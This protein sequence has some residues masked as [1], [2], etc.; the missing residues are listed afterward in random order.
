MKHHTINL[1]AVG[2]AVVASMIIP[3][4][5]Y[6]LFGPQW[7]DGNELTEQMIRNNA[8]PLPYIIAL[9]ASIVTVFTMAWLFVRLSVESVLNGVLT[10]LLLGLAFYVVS[11][12]TQNVFSLRPQSLTLIDG[13]AILV[14]MVVS[15]AILGGWRKYT[16]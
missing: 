14:S 3:A 9:I 12:A 1:F 6:F 2:A 10:A 5:W 13:G 11:L 7:M 8:G 16:D 15:G 4:A